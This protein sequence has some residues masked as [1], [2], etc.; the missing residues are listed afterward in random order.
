MHT[1]AN[2]QSRQTATRGKDEAYKH[3]IIHILRSLN[4][5]E[6]ILYTMCEYEIYYLCEHTHN[7]VKI[8]MVDHCTGNGM[9]VSLSFKYKICYQYFKR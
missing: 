4:A 8:P 6:T 1:V 2:K 3:T 9:Y 5:P 7:I